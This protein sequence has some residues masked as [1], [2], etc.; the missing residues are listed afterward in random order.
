M[1]FQFMIP[2]TDILFSGLGRFGFLKSMYWKFKKDIISWHVSYS[3]YWAT[4]KNIWFI[5]PTYSYLCWKISEKKLNVCLCSIA[6]QVLFNSNFHLQKTRA[7]YV[8]NCLR[9]R[10]IKPKVLT[11]LFLLKE[12]PLITN[13]LKRVID[14]VFFF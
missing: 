14:L 5:K 9:Y 13:L 1:I 4:F 6:T 12:Y 8:V 7:F 10:K 11:W 3:F 2:L